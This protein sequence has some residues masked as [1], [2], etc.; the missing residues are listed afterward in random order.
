[1]NQNNSDQSD[2]ARLESTN[3]LVFFF[4]WKWHIIAICFIAAVVSS[5]ASFMIEEKYQSTVI[6]FATEQTSIGEQF[7]EEVK[8]KDLLEYGEKDDAERLIQVLNSDKIKN[9]IISDFDLWTTYEI[10]PNDPGANDLISKEYSSNVSAKLTKFG[11]IQV[12]VMDKSPEQAMQMANRIAELADTV[13]NDMRSGR[14]L[15]A[16]AYAKHS[17]EGLL[18]EIRLLED[19]MGSLRELGVYD[20]ITQIEGLNDQFA[21]AIADGKTARAELLRLQ[22]EE[23]SRYGSI[24]AKLETLIESAYEREAVLKKRYDLMQIDADSKL[25][26]K[27]V[28]DYAA[29]SDKKAY[30]IRW[31]I[32]AM[33]VASTF[34]FLIIFLL[35]WDSLGSL[36][37]EGF[38]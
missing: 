4:R 17:Y 22:M 26:A 36:K 3:L 19:S 24:Y 15:E 20:Y 30:P 1:M 6:M 16:F 14:A 38:I 10:S 29:V 27:F 37:R 25:P 31:L 12:D 11:S 23:I 18:E 5:I 28:V 13:S 21:T 34:V 33:S 2:Q 7:L 8:R 9:R 32:V 35:I